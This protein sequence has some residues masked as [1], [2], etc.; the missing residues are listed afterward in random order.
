MPNDEY[1]EARS[2]WGL[3][4]IQEQL[5]WTQV[6]LDYPP[7]FLGVIGMLATQAQFGNGKPTIHSSWIREAES[8][9]Q[10]GFSPLLYAFVRERTKVEARPLNVLTWEVLPRALSEGWRLSKAVDLLNEQGRHA[11]ERRLRATL[12]GNG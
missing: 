4:P 12:G 2:I 9:S 7:R 3:M 6:F 8:F 5:S 11:L 10:A 1:F